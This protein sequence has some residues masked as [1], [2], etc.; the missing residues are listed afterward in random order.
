MIPS[1]IDLEWRRC[2][3]PARALSAADSPDY[4]EIA[5]FSILKAGMLPIK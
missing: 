4:A 3:L 1:E 2:F 5:G